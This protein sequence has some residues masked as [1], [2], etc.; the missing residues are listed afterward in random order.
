METT[1]P[2]KTLRAELLEQHLG[3]A[4]S[5]VGAKHWDTNLVLMLHLERTLQLLAEATDM[6]E[7]LCK[8]VQGYGLKLHTGH[9]LYDF[10]IVGAARALVS[11]GGVKSQKYASEW[12][13]RIAGYVEHFESD[14]M[15]K[16]VPA[17]QVAWTRQSGDGKEDK[18]E[19]KL[20]ANKRARTSYSKLT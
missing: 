10:L 14:G 6:L 12:L 18:E 2:T 19:D 13:E 5:V 9:V 1:T 11:L 17:L 16:V 20:D 8:F 3:L 4:S 7:R 15:Q